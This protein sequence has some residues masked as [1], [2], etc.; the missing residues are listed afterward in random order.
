MKSD[1]DRVRVKISPG[2]RFGRLEVIKFTRFDKERRACYLCKCDCGKEKEVGS[3]LLRK[4]VTKSCGCLQKDA[5]SN[6]RSLK[7]VGQQFERLTVIKRVPVP[8]GRPLQKA[9]WLCKCECGSNVIVPTEKLTGKE[10]R[11][12][13]CLRME[14][15]NGIHYTER[16]VTKDVFRPILCNMQRSRHSVS[17]TLQ[18]LKEVWAN[19]QGICTYT[20]LKLLLPTWGDCIKKDIHLASVDRIDSSKG[21]ERDNIQFVSAIANYAKNTFTHEQMVDFC[22][23]VAKKWRD[24]V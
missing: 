2:T 8:K 9:Y 13:G 3:R 11:S 20:G 15:L 14:R 1:E 10:T 23:I 22:K 24:S 17:L 4:G 18:D 6:A 21:Y 5:T 12:C 16:D 19:Q 7:L